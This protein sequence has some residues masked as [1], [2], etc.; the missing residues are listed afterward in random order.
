MAFCYLIEIRAQVPTIKQ[1]TDTIYEPIVTQNIS[2]VEPEDDNTILPLTYSKFNQALLKQIMYKSHIAT[3]ILKEQTTKV[4]KYKEML[5]AL[6]KQELSLKR[7]Q[8]RKRLK[9]KEEYQKLANVQVQIENS[10]LLLGRCRKFK[11]R[12]EMVR[13]M[14]EKEAKKL[15]ENVTKPDSINYFFGKYFKILD[16]LDKRVEKERDEDSSLETQD[17]QNTWSSSEKVFP[18]RQPQN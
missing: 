13:K 9:I 8:A 4:R 17:T 16:E 10:W 15:F 5:N 3:I 12:D 1:K 6:T 11:D 7:L 14:A 2:I 18:D